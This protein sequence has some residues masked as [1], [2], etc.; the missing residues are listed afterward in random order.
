M[1]CSSQT[2]YDVQILH[3]L[4]HNRSRNE[5]MH[6]QSPYHQ[7]SHKIVQQSQ[8]DTER[9]KCAVFSLHSNLLLINSALSTGITALSHSHPYYPWKV[10]YQAM[11]SC[12]LHTP[13]LTTIVE[14]IYLLGWIHFLI[15]SPWR[16]ILQCMPSSIMWLNSSSQ[17]LSWLLHWAG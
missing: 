16:L 13:I 7:S 4:W 5:C 14:H 10:I 17:L 12:M 11:K 1:I 15:H 8:T 2:L 6:M 9:A 3:W